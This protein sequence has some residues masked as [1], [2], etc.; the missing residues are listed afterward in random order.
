MCGRS[1]KHK[2]TV[3]TKSSCSTNAAKSP[4]VP[5]RISISSRASAFFCGARA[6]HKFHPLRGI[7][8][9]TIHVKHPMQVRPRR[10]SSRTRIAENIAAL[11]RNSRSHHESRHV[12]V[13]R[14]EALAVVDSHCVAKHI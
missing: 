7:H 12:Q 9:D 10:T 3:S 8:V 2:K 11:H 4:N 13:H 5:P 14:F 6:R 1:P